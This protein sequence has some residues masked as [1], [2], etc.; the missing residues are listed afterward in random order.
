MLSC[1]CL[2]KVKAEQQCIFLFVFSQDTTG[3]KDR[4]KTLKTALV[5]AVVI[6]VVFFIPASVF[7]VLYFTKGMPFDNSTRCVLCQKVAML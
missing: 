5:L 4:N 3:I 7:L 1:F 6:V 2:K